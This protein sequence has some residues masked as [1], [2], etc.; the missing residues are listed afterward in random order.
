[1]SREPVYVGKK[2]TI[3][4]LELADGSSPAWD[5]LQSL[6]DADRVKV[7]ALFAWFGDNGPITNRQKF[8]KIEE[9]EKISEF[10]SFQVRIFCFYDGRE[11]LLEFGVIK[12][13]DKHKRADIERAESYRRWYFSQK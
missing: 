13:K 10:K 7:T 11:V 8:K 4:C 6:G 3:R 2:Y 5:F 9:S 12:K 1:V